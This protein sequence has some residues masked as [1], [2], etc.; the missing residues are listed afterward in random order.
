M[1]L[2]QIALV[3]AELDATVK[4]LCEVLDLEVGFNDPGVSAFG[5]HNA[6]IPV[7]DTFLEVVSP[8][9]EGT[10]AGRLLERRA[11]DGGYMVILQSDDL[12]SDRKHLDGLGVRVVW[13]ITL[14]DIAAAHLH[15]K[16]V[17]GAIL[18][19][20]QPVPPESWRWGGPDWQAHRKTD[21]SLRLCAAEIQSPDPAARA[22]RWSEVLRHPV[23]D[24]GDGRYEIPLDSSSLRF[25][26]ERDGRGEGVSG[27]DVEV[28]DVARVLESARARG[29]EAA[30][31][32]FFAC[33]MRI[34]L[35]SA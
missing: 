34:G 35:R 9:E 31:D 2:R 1:R 7:G 27:V 10:T 14:D 13:D 30:S 6:V 18:S 25:V 12:A 32:H 23:I 28:T 3:A 24:T 5:L 20:D 26:P 17:G 8:V 19:L 4:E 15:P 29:L 16:D 21:T 11:G 22:A 33:G